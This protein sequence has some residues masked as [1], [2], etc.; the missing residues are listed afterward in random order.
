[1]RL[2][3]SLLRRF[4][5]TTG[6]SALHYVSHHNSSELQHSRF[7]VWSVGWSVGFVITIGVLRQLSK[8]ILSFSPLP[9]N[10]KCQKR[11]FNFRS[12][13]NSTLKKSLNF[14]TKFLP[15][16]L[17]SDRFLAGPAQSGTQWEGKEDNRT[18]DPVLPPRPWDGGRHGKYFMFCHQAGQVCRGCSEGRRQSRDQAGYSSKGEKQKLKEEGKTFYLCRNVSPKR[19]YWCR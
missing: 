10:N 16:L 7:V 8:P 14:P 13:F 3:S 19:C 6:R 11:A 1:M 17:V 5:E 12:N 4:P 2:W 9:L 18:A 15:V